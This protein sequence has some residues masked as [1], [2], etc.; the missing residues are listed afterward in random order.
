MRTAGGRTHP[1]LPTT[2]Q[3]QTAGPHATVST[4]LGSPPP[5]SEA[6]ALSPG[7][8]FPNS[9]LIHTRPDVPPSSGLSP[10]S[11]R[12]PPLRKRLLIRLISTFLTETHGRHFFPIQ[13]PRKCFS[14]GIRVVSPHTVQKLQ[15]VTFPFLFWPLGSSKLNLLLT[16]DKSPESFVA[17][18]CS[19][20]LL[21]L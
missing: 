20:F 13:V 14:Y 11:V 17:F 19:N 16:F 3:K 9:L 18:L 8:C 4:P 7:R 10:L 6:P 2:F 21:G 1:S 5:S 15:P 12:A